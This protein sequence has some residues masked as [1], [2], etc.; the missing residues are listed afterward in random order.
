MVLVGPRDVWQVL[1][2]PSKAAGW[3]RLPRILRQTVLN[4]LHFRLGVGKLFTSLVI[5]RFFVYA[6]W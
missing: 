1:L 4:C 5:R 3:I 6:R 2:S